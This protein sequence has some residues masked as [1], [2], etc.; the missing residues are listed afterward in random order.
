MISLHE[1]NVQCFENGQKPQR[2]PGLFPFLQEPY[3]ETFNLAKIATTS[4]SVTFWHALSLSC[5][6]STGI[7]FPLP[8]I[9][10]LK[11]VLSNLS[12]LS[13]RAKVSAR[14]P[15][16][17]SRHCY[18]SKATQGG[19]LSANA[20]KNMQRVYALLSCLCYF[21]ETADGHLPSVVQSKRLPEITK[22]AKVYHLDT[23]S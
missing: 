8:S 16:Y 2:N 11:G 20:H 10:R 19:W 6:F 17:R 7:S 5:L 12:S 3:L 14:A 18:E 23:S 15:F 22:F 21:G 4:L 1:S 9:K 13:S